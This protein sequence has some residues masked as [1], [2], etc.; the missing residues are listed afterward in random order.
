VPV[1]VAGPGRQIPEPPDPVVA[2]VRTVAADELNGLNLVIGPPVQPTGT[3]TAEARPRSTPPGATNTTLSAPVP[4]EVIALAGQIPEPPVVAGVRT[5]AADE[6]NGLDLAAR[7][8]VQPDGS[9]PAE[10]GPMLMG[11][12]SSRIAALGVMFGLGA[13]S[14]V[15]FLAWGV[16]RRAVEDP[17]TRRCT[18]ADTEDFLRDEN[19]VGVRPAGA[20]MTEP[21]KP[22]VPSQGMGAIGAEIDDV[23]DLEPSEYDVLSWPH[24]VPLYRGSDSLIERDGTR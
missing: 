18:I 23:I 15:G 14:V 2:G 19:R 22:R 10:A 16:R 7:P 12:T 3:N 11:P 20:G 13:V 6:L 1:E 17:K 5:V 4:V 8:P 21:P 24:L 9:N